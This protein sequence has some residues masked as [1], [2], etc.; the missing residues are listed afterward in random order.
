MKILMINQPLN[1]RGDESA[2]RAL[3]NTIL[4]EMDYMDI[5]MM[6]K[7]LLSLIELSLNL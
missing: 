3:V 2:H 1:N 4:R 7:N 5:M 6:E